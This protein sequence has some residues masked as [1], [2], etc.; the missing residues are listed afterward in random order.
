[1]NRSWKRLASRTLL[2]DRWLRVDADRVELPNGQILDPFYRC[3]GR[4]WVAVLPV[5][6]DGRLL[7]VEQYRH[8]T[9][10]LSLE[11]PAGNID[12]GEDPASAAQRELAEECGAHSL[13]ELHPLPTL[14]CD[15][16]RLSNRGFAFIGHI[17]D[18]FGAQ[19]LDQGEHLTIHCL[20]HTR[21]QAAIDCGRFSH[22][23][24]LAWYLM[25]RQQQTCPTPAR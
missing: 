24:H 18:E 1:M 19:N 4:D 16:Q 21:I 7:M 14:A 25:Y 13:Q 8:G 17:S 2:D 15:P 11:F 9:K 23:A 3:I 6:P 20:N 5:L 22:S 12:R 10:R